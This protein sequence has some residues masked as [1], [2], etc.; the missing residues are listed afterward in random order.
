[1]GIA[2]SQGILLGVLIKSDGVILPGEE[3]FAIKQESI[4]EMTFTLRVL[5]KKVE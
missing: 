4:L 3:D 1:M 2:G 5:S